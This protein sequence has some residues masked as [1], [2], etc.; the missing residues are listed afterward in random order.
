MVSLERDLTLDAR[1]SVHVEP[2]GEDA[3]VRTDSTYVLTKTISSPDSDEPLHAE[4]ISFR[5]GES[6]TFSS[7]TRCQPNGELE[8]LVLEALPTVSPPGS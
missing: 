3:I 7:G 5:I 2:S 1:M 6:G 8:R 4:T